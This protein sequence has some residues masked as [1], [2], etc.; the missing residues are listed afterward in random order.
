MESAPENYWEEVVEAFPISDSEE[1][2]FLVEGN[3]ILGIISI[4]IQLIWWSDWDDQTDHSAASDYSLS[5]DRCLQTTLSGMFKG[6]LDLYWLQHKH[7]NT[8]YTKYTVASEYNGSMDTWCVQRSTAGNTVQKNK[9]YQPI[10]NSLN[11]LARICRK[12]IY[13]LPHATWYAA[14]CRTPPLS[15][16]WHV[17]FAYGWSY[18]WCRI[19]QGQNLQMVC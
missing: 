2:P 12:N 7:T 4:S 18:A 9:A 10:D 6:K 1:A 13:V 11:E 5:E 15:C 14:S 3:A 16:Q 8:W 19:Y 17:S